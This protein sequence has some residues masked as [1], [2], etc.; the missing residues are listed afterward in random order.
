MALD[1][2][3]EPER[4]LIESEVTWFYDIMFYVCVDPEHFPSTS[5]TSSA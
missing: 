5:S 2:L 4:K 1:L 3:T